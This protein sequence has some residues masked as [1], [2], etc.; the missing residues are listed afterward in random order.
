MGTN[1]YASVGVTVTINSTTNTG[2]SASASHPSTAKTCT[3][4]LGGASTQEGTP[5]C[6]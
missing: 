1:Y 4:S 6:Q 2:W 3:I 5:V